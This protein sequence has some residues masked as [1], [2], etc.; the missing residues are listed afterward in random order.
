MLLVSH[1]GYGLN[2]PKSAVTTTPGV[3]RLLRADGTPVAS[4]ETGPL[5][6]VAN[7]HRGPFARITLP[8][9]LA[10][11][12]YV[13]DAGTESVTFTVSPSRLQTETIGAVLDYFTAMRS[14]GD[15]DRKDQHAALWDDPT[16]RTVDARGGWLDASGDTSKFLSHLTYTS[17]MS[18]QQIPLCVWAMLAAADALATKHPELSAK[19]SSRLRDEALWG[20][21]FLYRFRDPQGY[22]YTGIFDALTKKLD[23]RFVTAPL[24]NSVRTSR[25]QAGYRQ[26]GGLAIA[27]LA[28]T[29]VAEHR[30]AAVEA[31]RHLEKH[32]LEYLFDGTESIVDDYTALLAATELVAAGVL[33][34]SEAAHR[35]AA[36]LMAR[37]ASGEPFFHAVEA[38]LPVLALLRYAEVFSADLAAATALEVMRAIISRTNAV[39]NPFGYPRQRDAFFFPHDNETGYWWQG[40]NATIA[41]L[42][43]AAHACADLSTADSGVFLEFAAD[44]LAWIAGRN[45]FDACMIHG[46]GRNNVEYAAEFPNREG[47]IVNGITSGWTDEEDIAFLPSD[48][49]AGDSWRWAEQWIPHTGWF[50]LAVATEGAPT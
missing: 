12:T 21:D 34:A 40:E 10:A 44:Q 13:L 16:G 33:E 38:G 18:P 48:A 31:L 45:P 9:D 25:Y 46:K 42:A 3:V 50:L 29:G 15:I 11:G 23:E 47:G 26:G 27:A 14:S 35:R 30:D 8:R 32:N 2:S 39:P 22:F 17:K 1:L 49:P 7:W 19:L 41:S 24:Q 37:Y 43:A 36:Q 5:E 4:W 28:R 20:A 6:S